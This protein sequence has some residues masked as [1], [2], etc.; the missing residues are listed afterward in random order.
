[1][2]RH[3]IASA[4]LG[5]ALVV[6]AT[7]HAQ[8]KW[9]LASGYAAF[10]FH[11][12]NLAQFADDVQRATNG[13]LQ[14]TLHPGASLY[15][16]PEIKRAVQGEQIQ[17]G[18]FFLPN[19]QNEWP[20]FGTDG[21]P[22]LTAGY[23]DAFKLYQAQKPFLQKK[24]DQQN[25]VLLYSVPWPPQGI[26]SKMPIQSGAD[27]KG[28]KWRT[29]SPMLARIGELLGAQPATIQEADLAQAL[30]TG[31]VEAFATSSSTG[32]DNKV[33]E[34]LNY[35]TN[36]AGW[37]PKNAVVVNKRVFNAL[38]QATRDAVMRAAAAA[39]TRGWAMSRQ[40]DADSI[41]AL[42]AAGMQVQEPTAQL[43]A[44]LQKVGE[45]ILTEWLK[46]AGDDGKALLD[47]YRQ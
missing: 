22:F 14:I 38:D 8:V 43:R 21:L 45:A 4:A 17:A 35:Y 27:L 25:M 34:Q 18:E 11:V 44:D 16:M 37:I 19:F 31:V 1:M 7:A 36:V 47:A 2:I 10:N 33:Y 23:D 40:V 28:R 12:K 29:Y 30:A 15:K 13:Q 39:E 41:A 46:S 32:V 20:L 9:D 42:K 24:L 26:Y 3:L 6:P 5:A